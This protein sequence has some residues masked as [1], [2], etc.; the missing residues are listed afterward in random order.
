MRKK[1]SSSDAEVPTYRLP[2][3]LGA[4]QGVSMAGR[5][6]SSYKVV[7]E[8]TQV[9]DAV[10]LDVLVVA[11]SRQRNIVE[12]GPQDIWTGC[13]GLGGCCGCGCHS[14]AASTTLL[15]GHTGSRKADLRNATCT[16]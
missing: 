12:Q 16:T 4:K 7:G 6:D 8:L 9:V 15:P 3:G 14:G 1:W 13:H 11:L 2:S 5:M 10:D